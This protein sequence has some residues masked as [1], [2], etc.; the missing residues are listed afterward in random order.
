MISFCLRIV[1]LLG[2]TASPIR[3][4]LSSFSR[5]GVRVTNVPTRGRAVLSSVATTSHLRE[6]SHRS[7][8]IVEISTPKG[9]NLRIRRR[10]KNHRGH[11]VKTV[12]LQAVPTYPLS[13]S[14][15]IATTDMNRSTHVG[16]NARFVIQVRV[17]TV[18]FVSVVWWTKIR[19][20]LNA[21]Q[22]RLFNVLIRGFGNS[23]PLIPRTSGA[24]HRSRR[25]DNVPIVTADV[26]SAIVFQYR[27]RANLLL[28][29]RHVR[30]YPGH[31]NPTKFV[32]FS[33][34]SSTVTIPSIH[35]CV[36][37]FVF[38]RAN[39]RHDHFFLIR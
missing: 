32:S 27:Q 1:R 37:Q 10:A 29:L 19:S 5:L 21:N 7:D 3:I 22:D 34:S 4:F 12:Q 16:S 2:A 39:S 17:S 13:H 30:V 31:S 15:S 33:H 8:R 26:R 35:L 18:S 9:S 23:F 38:V 20:T 28:S 11:V 6:T 24:V 14:F 36:G 25:M